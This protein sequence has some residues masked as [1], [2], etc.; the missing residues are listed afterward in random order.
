MKTLFENHRFA[1]SGPS[2]F[3]DLTDDLLDLVLR[4]GVRTGMALVFS[5]HTTG[6][7]VIN[8][9]EEGFARDVDDLVQRLVPFEHE[10]AHD[11]A[12]LRTENL[13][14]EHAIPNGHAH[15]R[16][17]LV[18][19]PSQAIPIIEG[20]LQLGRWQRVF[21]FECDRSRDRRVLMQV[22]GE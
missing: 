12:D 11:D 8:E 17:A 6:A 14:D 9:R 3:V 16:H 15:C 20:T 21:F 19:A 7:I 10:Y 2:D 18:G 13:E 1:T 22:L 5:P 4:S